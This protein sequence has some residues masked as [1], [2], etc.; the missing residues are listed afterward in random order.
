MVNTTT[1]ILSE[2]FFLFSKFWFPHF[3]KK[4]STPPNGGS[5]YSCTTWLYTNF[6]HENNSM[7]II[8]SRKLP[9]IG[10]DNFQ[11]LRGLIT[12]LGQ[13]TK[14]RSIKRVCLGWCPQVQIFKSLM[15]VAFKFNLTLH[16]AQIHTSKNYVMAAKQFSHSCPFTKHMLN[17][18]INMQCF[19]LIPKSLIFFRTFAKKYMVTFQILLPRLLNNG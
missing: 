19:K 1:N 12:S 6:S 14:I 15:E 13:P 7:A 5:Q 18:L 11:F 2:F 8:A 4:I 17:L 16:H 10:T 9:I 3:L